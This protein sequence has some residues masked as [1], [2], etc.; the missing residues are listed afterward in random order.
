VLTFSKSNRF[1]RFFCWAW[2]SEPGNQNICTLFWGTLFIPVT[3]VTWFP[4]TRRI[5]VPRVVLPLAAVT[6]W[7]LSVGVTDGSVWIVLGMLLFSLIFVAEM[8]TSVLGIT[9]EKGF[10][11]LDSAPVNRFGAF[12]SGPV[13]DFLRKK[14][15]LITLA[16]L[17]LPVTIFLFL[18]HR[19]F[20]WLDRADARREKR[21]TTSRRAKQK[22]EPSVFWTIM[23]RGYRGLKDRTCDIV[24]FT[25]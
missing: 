12:M 23:R 3:L 18:M 8:F 5:R 17:F 25:D 20:A 14:P 11:V 24:Q 7:L 16:V 13:M 9:G 4:L 1:I 21:P 15:V 2:Q 22:R 10:Q 19:L 6:W